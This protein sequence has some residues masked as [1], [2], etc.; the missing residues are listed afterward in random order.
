MKHVIKGDSRSL[1]SSSYGSFP[2]IAV[3][4]QPLRAPFKDFGILVFIRGSLFV[5]L[6]QTCGSF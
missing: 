6:S 5:L 1:D 3:A 2:D 4:F